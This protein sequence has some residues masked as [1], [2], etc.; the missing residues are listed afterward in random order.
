METREEARETIVEVR[1]NKQE[2]GHAPGWHEE[3]LELGGAGA[4]GLG[5]VLVLG[6]LLGLAWLAFRPAGAAPREPAPLAV[7]SLSPEA[8]TAS[9]ARPDMALGHAVSFVADG[10]SSDAEDTGTCGLEGS[11]SDEATPAAAAG[12]EGPAGATRTDRAPSSPQALAQARER[13][14]SALDRSPDPV[15]RAAGLVLGGP[16]AGAGDCSGAACQGGAGRLAASGIPREKEADDAEAPAPARDALARLALAGSSPQV[17]ALA[18]HACHT[19]AAQGAAGACQ[20]LSAEQWARLDADNAVPWM[21]VAQRAQARGDASTAAEALFRVA[22]ARTMDARWG[23][24][25]SAALKQVPRDVSAV[26]AVQVASELLA[27]ETGAV[28]SGFQAA[29]AHCRAPLLVDTNRQQQCAEIADTFALRGRTLLEF[30]MGVAMGERVGW[31]AFRV[32]AT[33]LERDA[34]AQAMLLSRPAE[35][36]APT[37]KSAR[38]Q[39]AYLHAVASQGELAVARQAVRQS[40]RSPAELA[41]MQR[42]GRERQLASLQPVAASASAAAALQP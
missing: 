37:C 7:S 16:V 34:M 20:M 28:L 17:Y 5:G 35:S 18:W 25:A 8:T 30:T 33:K 4:A 41:Q 27:F 6:V 31:P 26:D 10:A 29:S 15:A 19:Q 9:P 14:R 21:D 1:E 11:G 38:Q 39:A 32:E 23:S 12:Q 24:L 42:S 40:G 3:E 2:A 13:I 22:K 36:G